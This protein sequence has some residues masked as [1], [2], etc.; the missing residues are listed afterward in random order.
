MVRLSDLKILKK[1]SPSIRCLESGRNISFVCNGELGEISK[2]PKTMGPRVSIVPF[3][4]TNLSFY[5]FYIG[6][7]IFQR[8][9][10]G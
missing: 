7:W 10:N 4:K 5:A 2:N 8:V 6:A 3:G 9:L 1:S